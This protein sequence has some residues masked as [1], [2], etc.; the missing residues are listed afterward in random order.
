M[1]KIKIEIFILMTKI[2]YIC[3]YCKSD[4]SLIEFLLCECLHICNH[5]AI[6]KQRQKQTLKKERLEV[7]KH[8]F[9]I[10]IILIIN[11]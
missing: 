9:N 2:K 8:V 5:C 10:F 1:S 4:V 11:L 6:C 3:F 7:T